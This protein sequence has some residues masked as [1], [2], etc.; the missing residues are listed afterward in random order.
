MSITAD[1]HT[2]TD[3]S[4]DCKTPMEEMIQKAL[5]LEMTHLCFTEHMDPDY[6]VSDD[7]LTFLLD[8]P[9]YREGFLTL[10]NSY[11]EKLKLLWGVELGIQ[12]HLYEQ[13]KTYV[14]SFPFDFVIGSSHV[15]YKED[16]YYPAFFEH[17]REETVYE[18]YFKGI[19]TN[20]KNFS[21]FDIYGHLDY[22]VRYGP[23]KDSRYSYEKYRDIF[24]EILKTL[25]HKGKGLEVNTGGLKYGL[26]DLHPIT[27]VLKQYKNLGGE[28]I[29]IGSDAHSPDYLQHQF[30]YAREV[31]LS[32]GYRYYSVFENRTCSFLPL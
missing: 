14:S 25:I 10:K 17:R 13:L 29:T 28:I 15:L 21:D 32:L 1:F 5:S 22:I 7:G 27:E 30:S 3:F 24:D 26:R 20:I 18:D 12:P 19:L 4:S 16:P 8:T 6:P 23:N 9:A 31:L 11:K 2:H